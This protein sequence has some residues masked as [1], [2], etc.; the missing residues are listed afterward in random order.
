M[1]SLCDSHG[2]ASGEW[3][4]INVLIN[5]RDT[6]ERLSLCDAWGTVAAA[7]VIMDWLGGRSQGDVQK[8]KPDSLLA[9]AQGPDVPEPSDSS[10]INTVSMCIGNIFA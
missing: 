10:C 7:I 6:L 2:W 5:G 1:F 3:L 9:P 8:K 4:A